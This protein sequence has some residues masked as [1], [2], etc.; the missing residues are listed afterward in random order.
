MINLLKVDFKRVIKDKLFLVM[1]IV[2]GAFALATPLLYV[3]IFS[4]MGADFGD[5]ESM[6]ELM[7]MDI[8]AK[9]MFF[10]SFS[11]GNNLGLVVPVLLTIVLCKDY[12]QGT[13]RNKIIGG[14]ART[15]IFLS[16]CVVCFCVLFGIMLAHALLTL[17]VSLCF[18]PFQ[19]TAF[20]IA[21]LGY[22][23]LSLLLEA[24][25]FAF[26]A[27]LVSY[28]CV[29]VKNMGIAIVAYIAIAMIMSI[30]STILQL[31]IALLPLASTGVSEVALNVLEFIQDINV[32]NFGTV[33]GVG[34][35]YTTREIL[36]CILSPIVF[37]GAF[38]ALGIYK[39]NR[40]DLK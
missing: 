33:I 28:L 25:L 7:G 8:N 24:L 11:L 19:A 30:V 3:G 4:L 27:A 2:A 6:I 20:G 14:S 35:E 40:K 37:G 36:C 5:A 26:V 34:T 21:D 1:C 39:F 12:T 29:S 15:P 13:V 16:T 17:I 32:F 10:S 22:F 38:V 9:S 31:G 18:F 23:M